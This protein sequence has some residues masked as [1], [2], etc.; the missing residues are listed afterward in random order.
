[1]PRRRMAPPNAARADGTN[2]QNCTLNDYLRLHAEL[3]RPRRNG[4]HLGV[5]IYTNL[6]PYFDEGRG[7]NFLATARRWKVPPPGDGSPWARGERGQARSV[8]GSNR[9]SKTISYC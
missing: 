1:M 2:A 8:A 5:D 6:P 3:E 9:R 4:S 7:P